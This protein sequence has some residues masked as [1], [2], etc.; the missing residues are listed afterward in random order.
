MVSLKTEIYQ[1]KLY[2]NRKLDRL[3][4]CHK[5]NTEKV[6]DETVMYFISTLDELI[7]EMKNLKVAEKKSDRCLNEN[8]GYQG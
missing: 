6:R 1:I 5:L 7:G 2:S 8:E 4:E 3:W